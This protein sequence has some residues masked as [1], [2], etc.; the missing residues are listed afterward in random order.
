MRR[1][2]VNR[3]D[4]TST[5]CFAVVRVAATSRERDLE[6]RAIAA[7]DDDLRDLPARRLLHRRQRVLRPRVTREKKDH[8]RNNQNERAGTKSPVVAAEGEARREVSA[9]SARGATQSLFET[10]SIASLVFVNTEG[11]WSWFLMKVIDTA[12]RLRACRRSK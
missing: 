8:D 5:D 4:A 3:G 12:M 10:I 6:E 7:G 11:C 9:R 2:D 1:Q